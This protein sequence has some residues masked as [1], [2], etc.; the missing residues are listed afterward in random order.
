MVQILQRWTSIKYLHTGMMVLNY[1]DLAVTL[2]F[3]RTLMTAFIMQICKHK[4][5]FVLES[6]SGIS[7]ITLYM[8]MFDIATFMRFKNIKH[9][10][11]L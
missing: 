6:K 9:T 3:H 4:S 1:E 11:Q 7:L 2:T 5:C 8:A 10:K